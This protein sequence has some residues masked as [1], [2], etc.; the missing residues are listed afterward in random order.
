MFVLRTSSL[1]GSLVI[2]I[3][4]CILAILVVPSV[5]KTALAADQVECCGEVSD[6]CMFLGTMGP[7][8][9]L[10]TLELPDNMDCTSASTVDFR[11]VDIAS[12][13]TEVASLRLSIGDAYNEASLGAAALLSMRPRTQLIGF[14]PCRLI[15]FY[16]E[17]RSFAW[18]RP[19]AIIDSTMRLN[20]LDNA[21]CLR[22]PGTPPLALVDGGLMADHSKCISVLT[23]SAVDS[24]CPPA[25]AVPSGCSYGTGGSDGGR[26]IVLIALLL[27]LRF[28]SFE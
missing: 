13:V 24:G 3:A 20:S 25:V 12:E 15:A 18:L 23:D 9:A 17:N 19:F 4:S 10:V 6:Y 16:W 5:S 2:K 26:A 1:Q 21:R 27:V 11:V 7:A 8:S 14:S 28:R 22:G